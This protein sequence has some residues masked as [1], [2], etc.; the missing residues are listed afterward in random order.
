MRTIVVWGAAAALVLV[1][2]TPTPTP[3]NPKQELTDA[4]VA[5]GQ[6]QDSILTLTFDTT[7]E[8]LAKAADAGGFSQSADAATKQA[9]ETLVKVLPTTSIKVAAHSDGGPLNTEKDPAKL[10]G[11]FQLSIDGKPVDL[12]WIDSRAFVH[13]DVDGLGQATGLFTGDQLRMFAAAQ[14]AASPWLSDLLA[15]KW[16]EADSDAVQGAVAD[17]QSSAAPTASAGGSIDAAKTV[18]LLLDNSEVTKA[19]DDTY[20]L[21]TDAAKLINAYAAASD[22]DD[23][24]AQQAGEMLA[25]IKE[26]ATLDSTVDV[27]DGK[28]SRAVVDLDDIARTWLKAEGPNQAQ[29]EKLAATDFRL[30]GVL[31]LATDNPNVAVPSATSTIPASDIEAMTP[32]G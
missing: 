10:D 8:E 1:G 28:V 9:S 11:T 29:I 20:T 13:A 32:E 30:D 26:G 5:T 3:A 25:G 4:F 19:D 12:T 17:A 31:G 22:S 14:G 16:V 27:A 18:T 15:G 24:T 7:A 23:F 2:C 21:V 6:G